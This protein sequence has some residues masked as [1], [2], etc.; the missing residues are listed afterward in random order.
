MKRIWMRVSVLTCAVVLT[1]VGL[2]SPASA[3]VI[4]NTH[5]C[6]NF[7]STNGSGNRAGHCADG[8]RTRNADGDF[9]VSAQGQAF[10][11]RASNGQILQC[12]GIR[13]QLTI[14]NITLNES[15][16]AV[17]VTCGSFGGGACPTGRFQNYS[18]SIRA[19]CNHAY[20]ARVTTTV[21]LPGGGTRQSQ[22]FSSNF[23]FSC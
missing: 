12:G 5:R 13:Q 9:F 14:R 6:Q 3:E 10:C 4:P 19:F 21:V 1:L 15:G 23:G 11:Q 2:A 18:G 20:E 22:A 8:Y 7:G 16:R 17:T